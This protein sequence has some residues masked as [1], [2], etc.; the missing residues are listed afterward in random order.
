MGKDLKGK[1]LG[2]GVS[3]R[4]DGYYAARFTDHLGKRQQKLF[5]KLQECRKWLDEAKYQ[6]SCNSSEFSSD[7]TVDEWYNVWLEIKE[8]TVKES[9]Y[10]RYIQEYKK[11]IKPIIGNVAISKVKP[12]HCQLILNHMAER[13]C[14]SSSIEI[15]RNTLYNLLEYAVNNDVIAKNPCN[16]T[17]KANIGKSSKSREA[18]TIDQQQKLLKFIY[19]SPY[20]NQYR[21]VL[22][23]GLRVG[24]LAG[25]KWSDI[26][27][28]SNTLTVNRSLAY[29]S[30]KDGWIE[31]PPKSEA[32]LRTI[33]L[34]AEAV[35]ILNSQKLKNDSIPVISME[36][37]D[38]VFLGKNGY[39]G[40]PSTYNMYLRRL[41]KK[42]GLPRISM[43]ILRHTFATRCIEA[44][45][46][47]KTLQ[48]LLGHTTI[49]MT[50]NR[51]VSVTEAEKKKEIQNV[52]SALNVS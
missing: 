47:P 22:Q 23:T 2:S 8:K 13:E 3:Q 39:P 11:D 26:D 37:S 40:Q 31:G 15:T 16:G 21:F 29:K 17:V 33:P 44:G 10:N 19:G 20:E 43:H 18:M 6:D 48:K 38:Y 41:C 14:K 1:E 27:F 28:G 24:E 4:K 49:A 32:G 34:T 9:T 25:L 42:I 45:M 30:K 46:K 35:D 51:Y 50:M 52:E 36:W 7:I 5:K 12:I